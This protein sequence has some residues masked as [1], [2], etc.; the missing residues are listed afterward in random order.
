MADETLFGRGPDDRAETAPDVDEVFSRAV[1]RQLEEQRELNRLVEETTSRLT[2]LE[3]G[4][5]S[6][7]DQT[8]TNLTGLRAE[9]Q[10][11]TA[12]LGEQVGEQV[13]QVAAEVDRLRTTSTDHQVRLVQLGEAAESAV[14]ALEAKQT[15]LADEL[16]DLAERLRSEDQHDALVTALDRFEVTLGS[17]LDDRF[18]ALSHRIGRLQQHLQEELRE[19]L[20]EDEDAVDLAEELGALA[21]RID[22]LREHTDAARQEAAAHR[23]AEQQRLA[24]RLREELRHEIVG[25]I[26]PLLEDR[27]STLEAVEEVVDRAL[28]RRAA[29][30]DDAL[31]RL[32]TLVRARTEEVDRRLAAVAEG[33]DQVAERG[34][35]AAAHRAELREDLAADHAQL[36]E[37]LRARLEPFDS[38]VAEVAAQVQELAS[39]TGSVAPDLSA[40]VRG[41][42]MPIA[43][44]LTDLQEQLRLM[45]ASSARDE[46]MLTALRDELS[47]VIRSSLTTVREAL[48]EHRDAVDAGLRATRDALEE[49]RTG[50]A[51]DLRADRA[52]L[53]AGVGE[54]LEAVETRLDDLDQTLRTSLPGTLAGLREELSSTLSDRLALATE[55]L[56]AAR[57][58]LRGVAGELGGLPAELD[59]Q[60]ANGLDRAASAAREEARAATRQV[61]E[62]VERLD[63]VQERL[64]GLETSLVAYLEARDARLEEERMEV[65]RDLVER[66]AEGLS[67]RQRRRLARRLDD[68]REQVGATRTDEREPGAGPAGADEQPGLLAALLGDAGP[69]ERPDAPD[70][71]A[72]SPVD[73][74]GVAEDGDPAGRRSPDE[75]VEEE[76]AETSELRCPD[77]GFAAGNA[78]GLASHRRT[79]R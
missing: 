7:R 74:P 61:A 49:H 5:R 15:R 27:G 18:G 11:H 41:A 48:D 79:H 14:S 70:H 47:E 25:A 29:T 22:G 36:R 67:R 55:G 72:R 33:L 53:E 16:A 62:A 1:E 6:F 69:D 43:D 54:L 23:R 59:H 24:E 76:A 26:A 21:A 20:R 28:T 44:E 3:E 60:V 13:R 37:D 57:E 63:A 42:L 50:V 35:T 46:E 65:L 64:S 8:A 30:I 78:G 45:R 68:V 31:D 56:V 12:R 58:E 34:E 71:A 32:T 73:E 40:R 19:H 10:E 75:G 51:T 38:R 77:C 9:V 39:I 17:R 4:L 66:F 2:A 52:E